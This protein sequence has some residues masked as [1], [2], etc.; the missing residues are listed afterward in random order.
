MISD[1]DPTI[2]SRWDFAGPETGVFIKYLG[3]RI[4]QEILKFG[5]FIDQS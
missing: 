4:W 2:S 1:Q 3:S 5:R